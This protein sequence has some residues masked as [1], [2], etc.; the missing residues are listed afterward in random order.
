MWLMTLN[1]ACCLDVS[2]LHIHVSPVVF[3]PLVDCK[4]GD[5]KMKAS[6]NFLLA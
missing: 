2:G 5:T 6:L 3:I 1:D 4:N